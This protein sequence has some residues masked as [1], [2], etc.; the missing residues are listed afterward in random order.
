MYT[1]SLMITAGTGLAGGNTGHFLQINEWG[2]KSKSG[3]CPTWKTQTEGGKKYQLVRK[4]FNHFGLPVRR[5]IAYQPGSDGG[6]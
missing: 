6:S 2:P 4:V 3:I 5:E 1:M